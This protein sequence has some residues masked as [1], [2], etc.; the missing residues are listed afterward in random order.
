MV[1]N[2]YISTSLLSGFDQAAT[3]V[4]LGSPSLEKDLHISIVY[5]DELFWGAL[6]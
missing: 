5:L 2:L 4:R 3:P 1:L 6:Q